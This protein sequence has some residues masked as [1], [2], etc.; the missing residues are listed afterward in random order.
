MIAAAEDE[1]SLLITILM[2]TVASPGPDLTMTFILGMEINNL[3]LI[4]AIL[5]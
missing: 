5:H 4:S 3:I 1:K 2:H